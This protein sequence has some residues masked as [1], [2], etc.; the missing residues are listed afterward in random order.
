VNDPINFFSEFMRTGVL[1]D[2]TYDKMIAEE[3]INKR[4]AAGAKRFKKKKIK[5]KMADKS[6]RRNR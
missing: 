4:R 2:M 1:N 3:V 6:K 5:K